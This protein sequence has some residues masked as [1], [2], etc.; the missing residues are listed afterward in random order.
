MPRKKQ[1]VSVKEDVTCNLIPMVDIMFLLLLFFILGADMTQ[2]EQADLVLPEASEIKE[3]EKVKS[4]DP[5][6][7][8]NVQHKPDEGSFR[9]ATNARGEPCRE[10]EHWMIVVRGREVPRAS[11]RDQLKIEADEALEPDVDP[12]AGV[13]LSARKIVIRADRL[14]PYGDVN[15]II[16][17]CSQVGIYR[18][19]VGAAVP[20][21]G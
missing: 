13:R 18:V 2:R 15:K 7:T 4:A 5:T 8:V 14:A 21:K 9:C 12:V 3:N 6:T 10:P 20:P 1:K 16:E 11:L 17:V 19:E